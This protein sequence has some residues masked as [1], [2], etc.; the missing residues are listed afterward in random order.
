LLGEFAAAG[1]VGGVTIIPMALH[2]DYWD[3]LGWRDPFSAAKFTEYQEHYRRALKA[4]NLYTPQMVVDGAAGFVGSDRAQALKAIAAAARAAKAT[5]HIDLRPAK[6]GQVSVRIDVPNRNVMS[7]DQ[8]YDVM[9]A[10]TED[11]LTTE[12]RRGE[13]AGRKLHHSSVVRSLESLGEIRAND[14]GKP[15]EKTLSLDPSWRREHLHVV[16]FV[17]SKADLH[18]VGAATAAVD[19]KTK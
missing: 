8:A 6:D 10:V 7:A 19:A 9:L 11:D 17:Q 18:V 12:V 3:S 16:A 13:N 2:I 14:E 1:T 5:V 4:D 15:I